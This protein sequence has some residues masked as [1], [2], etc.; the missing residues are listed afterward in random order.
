M[1][2]RANKPTESSQNGQP[3]AQ[4][5]RSRVEKSLSAKLAMY[6]L[7]TESGVIFFLTMVIFG[8]KILPAAWAF[9]LGAVIFLIFLFVGR[10]THTKFGMWAGWA[11]QLGLILLGFVMT[12][13]FIIGI[14]F[15]LI[16][17]YTIVKAR[18]LENNP[19]VT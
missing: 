17:V 10:I 9:S 16:W 8:L 15:A 13:M 11:L 1:N 19:P 2:K 6:L 5:G 18:Q 7:Y 4:S 12:E 3:A 14:I